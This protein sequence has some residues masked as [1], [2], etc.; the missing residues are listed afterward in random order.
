MIAE[1]THAAVI[2]GGTA[3]PHRFGIDRW[4]VA[5][6]AAGGLSVADP[7]LRAARQDCR[8]RAWSGDDADGSGFACEAEL[9]EVVRRLSGRLV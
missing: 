3:A 1:S 7:L 8:A 6:A 4:R 9:A 2:G 5:V